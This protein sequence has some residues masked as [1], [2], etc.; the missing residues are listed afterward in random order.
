[1]LNQFLEAT[2]TPEVGMGVTRLGY[3]DRSPFTVLKVISERMI[4]VQEDKAIRM[5][6]NGMSECQEY[7]YER[8]PNGTIY[9][10]T[11]RKNGRWAIKGTNGKGTGW[12]IGE[13]LAYY[14]YSF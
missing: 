2:L 12:Q 13:R 5:D 3:T 1:M 7:R 6:T 11:K 8:D 9:T 14:D 10:L 4:V